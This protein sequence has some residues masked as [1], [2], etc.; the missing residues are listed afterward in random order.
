M[1]EK[2]G[3]KR[4]KLEDFRSFELLNDKHRK[5]KRSEEKDDVKT[6]I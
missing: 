4:K 5:K 1:A 3:A 6:Q 2:Q